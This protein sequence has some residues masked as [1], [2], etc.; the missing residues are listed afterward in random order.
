VFQ[1]VPV[2]PPQILPSLQVSPTGPETRALVPFQTL[3]PPIPEA[4]ELTPAQSKEIT[5]PDALPA[6]TQLQPFVPHSREIDLADLPESLPLPPTSNT[7]L[8]VSDAPPTSPDATSDFDVEITDAQWDEY[9]QEELEQNYWD[10]RRERPSLAPTGPYPSDP[11]DWSPR[12]SEPAWDKY[13]DPTRSNDTMSPAGDPGKQPAPQLGAPGPSNY[14]N[15]SFQPAYQQAY[16]PHSMNPWVQSQDQ[17]NHTWDEIRAD[18][19]N[20]KAVYEQEAQARQALEQKNQTMQDQLDY[21]MAAH[22]QTQRQSGAPAS[23]LS[24]SQHAPPQPPRPAP[25][26][27]PPPTGPALP[28]PGTNQDRTDDMFRRLAEFQLTMA[29]NTQT[30]HQQLLRGQQSLMQGTR[31]QALKPDD[32]GKFEPAQLPDPAA[33]MGF[34]DN[35]NKAVTYCGEDRVLQLMPRCCA[36]DLAKDWLIGLDQDDQDALTR[37]TPSWERLI[38]RDFMPR[39]GILAAKARAE[40]FKWSQNRTPTEYVTQK[41]KL[42]RMAGETNQDLLVEEVHEGFSRCPELHVPLEQSINDTGGNRIANYRRAVQRI[43]DSTKLQYEFNR[44]GAGATAAPYANRTRE[45]TSYNRSYAPVSDNRSQNTSNAAQPAGIPPSRGARRDRS[46]V[47]RKRKCKNYPNCGD[48]EHFDWECTKPGTSGS[49]KRAYYIL[50]DNCL[51]NDDFDPTLFDMVDEVPDLESE[52][53]HEQHAYFA[54]KWKE[55]SGFFGNQAKRQPISAAPKPSE[56]R[57]CREA[58]PSRT[59]LHAHLLAT[60]HNRTGTDTPKVIESQRIAPLNPEARL[61]GY[62]FAKARFSLQPDA[63]T[64]YIACLD[65]GYGNSAV[66]RDYITRNIPNPEF[67]TLKNP[68]EVR[69]IGGGIAMCTQLLMLPVYWLTVNGALAKMIRPFHVFPDLGVDLLCGVDTLREEGID[70]YY[71]SARPQMRIASCAGVSVAIEVCDGENVQKAPVHVA[72]NVVIPANSTSVIPIRVSRLLPTNQDY[73]FTPSQLKSISSSGAGAPHSVFSHDQKNVMF[74]N[75]QDTDLTL[76]RGTMIGHLESTE[77]EQV[78]V[79]HEAAQEVRGFLGISRAV[80]AVTAALAFSAAAR[81]T[82]NPEVESDMSLPE[83]ADSFPLEAPRPRPCPVATNIDLPDAKCADEI[84]TSPQWLDDPYTPHY[85]YDLPEDIRVPDVSTTTYS[86]VVINKTD[87]I[88][89]A[90]IEALRKLVVRHPYLFNDGMGCVREPPH[91]WMRLP[92]DRAYE[93]QLKSGGPYKLSRRGESAVD[94]NFDELRYYGRLED[95]VEPTPW[96]LQVFVVYKT[97]KELPVIDMR[98]LND[99]LA[100]DSYPLP[101]MESIIDPLKGM[102]WLGTVDIISAFYQRLLHPE[103]RHRA[104]VIT[105]RGVQRFATTV[106]GC[107]NSV[108]HQQRLM[109]KRVLSKLSWRGASCYVDDIVLYAESFDKFLHITDEV[110]RLLSDLAITLKARKCFLG[111]H[112]VE[113]LGYLVDRLG[114]T[115]TESKSD[116][117]GMIPFPS[118]LAQLEYFIGL[119]NWNRH[120]LPYYAQRV[121]PLQECKTELLKN[122][123]QTGRARK[124]YASKTPVPDDDDILKAAFIDLRDSLAARPKLHHAQDGKPIYAFLDTSREYGTGLAVYQLTGYP[125]IYCKTRLVPLHFLSKRLTAAEANYWPTDMELSGL[126]WSAK[127]LRPYMERCFVWFVTDHRPNVDIF[128]MRTLQTT[129]TSRSNLRLQTWGIYL[130]QFWGKMQVVY[131]KGTQLDCPD[132]LSRLKCDI[133]AHAAKLRDWATS[134]GKPH[135]TAEFEVTEAFAITRSS[136]LSVEPST[137]SQVHPPSNATAPTPTVTPSSDNAAASTAAPVGLT[138][139]A[140]VRCKDELRNAVRTSARFAAIRDRL[141]QAEKLVIDGVDDYELPETCQYEL[142]DDILY[143]RDPITSTQRLVLAGPT[144]HKRHLTA[145]HTASHYGYARM[146]DALKPY[147]WPC[148]SPAVRDFLNHCPDCRRNKP[149]NHRPF[150]LLSPIPTPYEP[151]DTRFIDLVTDLPVSLLEHCDIAYD[152]VMT[153]TDKYTKAVRFLPGRKDWSAAEWAKAV[154]EGV[155]LNGWGYPRT[156]ISD[157]YRRFLSALWTSIL[158]LSGTRHITTTA[159]HPSADGQAER[160]NFALEVSLRFFVNESQSDWVTKLKVIE[161]QMN[162]TLSATTKHAPNEILYGKKV[163]LDLTA[164]LSDLPADADEL[165][166]RREAIREDASRAIAFAQKAMKEVYDRRR[167][168]VIANFETGWAFLNIG[169]GYSVPRFRKPKLGPQ[170]IGPFRIVEVLSKGKAYKLD[171]PPHYQIHNVISIAHLEPAPCPGTDP[172]Q[173]EPQPED[174]TPVYRDGQQEWELDALVKKRTTGRTKTVEYL[175]R[176]K[177]HGPEWDTW[178]KLTE[179]ENAKEFVKAFEEQE[180]TTKKA[181]KPAGNGR[182]GRKPKKV[183]NE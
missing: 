141:L 50:P 49:N 1:A 111:F 73:L 112:S 4:P 43:Q 46:Q 177:N 182:K 21:L 12:S 7:D 15:P 115:T 48:G 26:P 52:Y 132:A 17:R 90:Q 70:M 163:R 106:M 183:G 28:Q 71:S 33:A 139:E 14:Q 142:H 155:T 110:F 166:L 13:S 63:E 147:Y 152:T 104:T 109:D 98:K 120:L 6:E 144:L 130:S 35:F 105:H 103:D 51:D 146:M 59:R 100:G 54:H 38:R 40:T 88:P 167:A 158:E 114:L 127:K 99:G 143:L 67:H 8:I 93:L 30:T 181:K 156:L 83:R 153:V 22:E 29:Q 175:G 19:D 57:T 150:G 135:D 165:L 56:C 68:K 136:A 20:W 180:V 5:L 16:Q 77:S 9:T 108:Q 60:G 161:A 31:G 102:R 151:F 24:A 179:L 47:T 140:S 80:S 64:T 170:R 72:A 41:M 107:K 134:L 23:G 96:S 2:L 65:S 10:D 145:A 42:F 32:I 58:F 11:I 117:I 101:R 122:G 119:T 89:Q 162:N 137:D 92:V 176:W 55:T 133:S 87:D 148:M 3:A 125:T 84:W 39:Q 128:D 66:D 62:H 138:I 116:A 27:I 168:S 61:S 44:K 173:R 94:T 178:L 113:L 154:Y 53:E 131:S 36:N 37:G 160:T 171:L 123:P 95:A 82:F 81:P 85:E 69:G 76:F 121:A 45:N 91:E 79:W 118:A 18:I 174:L 164:S 97:D 159:Y 129:S 157:R 169:H 86:Q 172:Y 74:T 75:A 78:A 149:T 34:I 126:V 25:A 124:I